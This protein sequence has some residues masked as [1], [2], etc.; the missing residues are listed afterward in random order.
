MEPDEFQLKTLEC[1]EEV[2]RVLNE[3]EPEIGVSALGLLESAY[4]LH[5]ESLYRKGFGWLKTLQY[6]KLRDTL[7]SSLTLHTL[8]NMATL[9]DEQKRRDDRWRI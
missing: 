3:Y 5:V 7:A 9:D 2:L 8:V 6:R 1:L 4:R